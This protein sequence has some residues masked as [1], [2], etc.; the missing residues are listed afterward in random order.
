[1]LQN[2]YTQNPALRPTVLIDQV[3]MTV[4]RPTATREMPA[5]PDA[6]TESVARET[7]RAA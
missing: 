4:Y 3:M 5:R 7:P 1:M 6:T 2:P